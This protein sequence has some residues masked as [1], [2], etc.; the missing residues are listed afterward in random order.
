MKNSPPLAWWKDLSTSLF[1]YPGEKKYRWVST[2]WIAALFL[3]GIALWGVFFS[4]GSFRLDF[5]DWAYVSGPRLLFLK[6]AV[7][8]WVFP[9]HISGSMTLGYITNRYLA[10][11][12]TFLAPQAL[13]L[14]WMSV[15]QFVLV[16]TLLL[17]ALGF[18]G[19]LVFRARF[20]LSALA[21]TFLFLLFNFNGHILAHYLVGHATW[22]GYFLF[23]WFVLLVLELMDGNHRWS[24]VAKMAGLLFLILLQASFHQF[25]WALLF[26]LLL[27]VFIPRHFWTALK[28]VAA[29][30]LLGM[31][32]LLP[33]V[34]LLGKFDNAPIGGYPS[35]GSI[36]QAMVAIPEPYVLTTSGGLNQPIGPFEYNLYLGLA[37]AIFVLFFG[38]YRW[39]RRRPEKGDYRA[40]A[41]PL[42]GLALL[43][44]GNAYQL[45]RDLHVPLFNGERV[46]SR[47][48]S[49]VFV[50]VLC[51]AVIEFQYWLDQVR[52][53][54]VAYPGAAFT[55]LF[56]AH[57][58]IQNLR[59]LRIKNMDE[60]FKTR[61][62]IPANWFVQND[63]SDWRYLA[64][65]GVG[66]TVS[67]LTLAGLVVMARRGERIEASLAGRLKGKRIPLHQR[68]RGIPDFP[69]KAS[70]PLSKGAGGI[71]F[72]T[73]P[74]RPPRPAAPGP[75]A[76]P[77]K[78]RRPWKCG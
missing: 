64:V 60:L 9:L 13:L 33:P 78:R 8:R 45:V 36:W 61:A 10:V 65:I 26:L 46:T 71:L 47:M 54:Q 69:N 17:Y 32:R 51:F 15:Q 58:L 57:D 30:V 12:D 16:D 35:P 28:A 41:L 25:V 23:P 52:A 20:K 19:W 22:G 4:W 11:P 48:I 3:S 72:F 68:S 55:A 14:R 34:L 59:Y 37:G 27:A 49:L 56:V 39:L 18:A 70:T 63:Y 40:L 77:G 21:F 62:F 67:L 38:V 31:L 7:T 50:F 5:Q 6:D 75:P 1:A 44:L 66:L 2:L 74:A 73:Y 76:F 42:A 29:S 53:R 24:W 43:T